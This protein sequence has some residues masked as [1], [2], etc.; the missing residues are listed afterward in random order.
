MATP[1]SPLTTQLHLWMQQQQQ[2]SMDF[3]NVLVINSKSKAFGFFQLK[4]AFHPK[5]LP[6]PVIMLWL[7]LHP[8]AI[9]LVV[10]EA[11]QALQQ[12]N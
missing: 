9:S 6:V 3:S 1:T 12:T 2:Q 10:T 11:I 8:S 5:L 4:R 7:M